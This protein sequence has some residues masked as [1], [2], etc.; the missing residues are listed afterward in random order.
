MHSEDDSRRSRAYRCMSRCETTS[1]A[2][3]CLGGSG[4]H[5]MEFTVE[6]VQ[7]GTQRSLSCV[8]GLARSLSGFAV[9]ASHGALARS[10]WRTHRGCGW[11]SWRTEISGVRLVTMVA[12]RK[13]ECA[14][15]KFH[16]MCPTPSDHSL[17]LAAPS[18]QTPHAHRQSLTP[19]E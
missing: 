14:N 3:P 10:R 15:L 2:H 9:V 4:P 7:G 19:R 12:L 18:R 1:H 16:A 6:Q 17:C 8:P 11:I 5:C 13:N